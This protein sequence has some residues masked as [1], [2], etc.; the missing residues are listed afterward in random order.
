MVHWKL[1]IIIACLLVIPLVSA[2][3]VT[4]SPN[5]TVSG[6]MR[7][8][9][10]YAITTSGTVDR[11]GLE[12]VP[13]NFYRT[14]LSFNTINGIPAGATIT[15]VTLIVSGRITNFQTGS[16]PSDWKT[17]VNIGTWINGVLDTG[18]WNGGTATTTYN[19]PTGSPSNLVI[20]LGS[21]ALT[22]YNNSGHTDLS[23][24]DSSDYI[25]GNGNWYTTFTESGLKLNVT[26]TPAVSG[27]CGTDYTGTGNW[28]INEN[29]ECNSTNYSGETIGGNI[30]INGS[31][32]F[33]LNEIELNHSL[34]NY[35]IF[36]EEGSR[37]K[38]VI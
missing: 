5:A 27:I 13:F 10:S 18:D 16:N 33:L 31:Y 29:V 32:L 38:G 24:T 12:L 9:G 21:T 35:Y 28:Y 4:F 17:L 6:Y 26:Y 20:D 22:K 34:A 25:G 11:V 23:L 8:N 19:W 36:G 15:N 1:Y 2:E 7:F 37:W 14:Y 3:S 30:L